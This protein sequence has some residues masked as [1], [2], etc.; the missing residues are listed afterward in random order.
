LLQAKRF[1]KLVNDIR[2]ERWQKV[3]RLKTTGTKD[4]AVQ[5]YLEM[6]KFESGFDGHNAN[7]RLF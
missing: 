7:E 3:Q 2:G 6:L 4:A 5:Q 1:P